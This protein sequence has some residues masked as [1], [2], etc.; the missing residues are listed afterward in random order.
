V[1]RQEKM[2][3]S[4]LA[5]RRMCTRNQ[6]RAE[7]HRV[8]IVMTQVL[9]MNMYRKSAFLAAVGMTADEITTATVEVSQRG[10]FGPDNTW[11]SFI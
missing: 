7:V 2:I 11:I 10:Y 6:A 1:T 3:T 5:E 4:Y 9:K 8:A